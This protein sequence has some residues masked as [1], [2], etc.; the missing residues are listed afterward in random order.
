[1]AKLDYENEDNFFFNNGNGLPEF[2]DTEK[3]PMRARIEYVSTNGTL[4]AQ[5]NQRTVFP[6]WFIDVVNFFSNKG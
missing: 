1:V 4:S 3:S 2:N 5:F 6:H